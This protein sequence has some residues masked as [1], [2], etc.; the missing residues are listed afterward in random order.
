MNGLRVVVL[1]AMAQVIVCQD[2]YKNRRIT[3]QFLGVKL[4]AIADGRMLIRHCVNAAV[5]SDPPLQ[6][7]WPLGVDSAFA[8]VG[9]DRAG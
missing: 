3:P 4:T 5:Q 7:S 1:P 6:G 9:D 2:V 8:E